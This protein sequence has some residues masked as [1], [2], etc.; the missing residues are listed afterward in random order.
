MTFLTTKIGS[1]ILAI[2][3]YMPH[4]NTSQGAHD[5]LYVLPWLTKTLTEDHP[6]IPILMEGELK[7]TP[8]PNHN[9]HSQTLENFC[10]ITSLR[11]LEDPHTRA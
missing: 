2:A 6:D 11:S 5:Y 7:V 10:T 9:S 4:H 8:F 1:K 3:T